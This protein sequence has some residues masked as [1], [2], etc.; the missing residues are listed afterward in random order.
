M[1]TAVASFTAASV[2][3]FDSDLWL[4]CPECS[5]GL[6]PI[7]DRDD[8]LL[9]ASIECA[10]CRHVTTKR[11]GVW[12]MLSRYQRLRFC[13]FLRDY[14]DIRRAEGRGSSHPAFY[15]ALP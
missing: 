10:C 9:P 1:T 4:R 6:G 3:P 12:R 5:A 11:N 15:L 8:S 2:L 7:S 13:T 14:E